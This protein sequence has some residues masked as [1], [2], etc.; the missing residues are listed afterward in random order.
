MAQIT[1]TSGDDDLYGGLFRD[2]IDGLGGD[3][4]ID[5]HGSNDTLNGGTGDDTIFGSD[6]DDTISGGDS[7]DDSN[8]ADYL[9]GGD[10]N[11]IIHGDDG[12]DYLIGGWGSDELYGGAGTDVIEFSWEDDAVDGG[13]GDDTLYGNPMGAVTGGVIPLLEG[14]TGSD[15]LAVHYTYDSVSNTFISEASLSA[16]LLF[17]VATYSYDDN[18]SP[19][20][21]M[22]FLS[23]IENLQGGMLDDTLTGDLNDNV[24]IGGSGDDTLF[25]SDG[26]D[27][28]LSGFDYAD[29]LHSRNPAG[30]LGGPGGDNNIVDGGDGDDHIHAFG[31]YDDIS[32]GDGDDFIWVDDGAHATIDGGDDTDTLYFHGNTIGSTL[33]LWNTIAGIEVIRFH[34]GGGNNLYNSDPQYNIG[35]DITLDASL[36]DSPDDGIL[37]VIAADGDDSLDGSRIADSVTLILEGGEGDDIFENVGSANITGGDVFDGGSGIDT[38]DLDEY[39]ASWGGT[40]LVGDNSTVTGV[41]IINLHG[42]LTTAG[43]N[44]IELSIPLA[45]TSS[46]GNVTVNGYGLAQDTINGSRIAN[47]A[48]SLFLNGNGGNDQLTGGAG[49]DMLNGGTGGDAMAGGSGNDTYIV[50][51]VTDTVTENLLAGTSDGVIASVD[52]TLGANLEELALSGTADIDGTGNS[53]VNEIAGN[54]GRNRL[55]GLGGADHLY[56]EA[57]DDD[58]FGGESNDTLEGGSENDE[59]DGGTGADIMEGGAGDDVY[60][61]DD[62]GDVVTELS[63]Q[64]AADLIMSSVSRILSFFVENLW[65]TGTANI[66]GVGNGLDNLIVGNGGNNAL[67][68][69]AGADSLYGFGGEDFLLGGAG[70]DTLDGGAGSDTA[71]YTGSAAVTIDLG[72]HIYLGGDAT[73][74]TLTGIENVTGSAFAD[75]LVGDAAANI[76][77]GGGSDDTLNGGAGNDTMDGGAGVDTVSYSAAAGAVSIDLNVAAQAATGGLGTDTLSSIENV[78]GGT[79]ADTL[80]GNA[81][82]NKLYGGAGLDTVY[83]GAGNDVIEGGG[84]TDGLFGGADSDTFDYNLGAGTDNVYDFINDVDTIQVDGAY[85]LTAAQV[86]AQTSVYGDHAYVNLGGGNGLILVNWILNGNT[87][88]Q[89]SDDIVI[90]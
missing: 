46:T 66:L 4:T 26:D 71:L 23:G 83:G 22:T 78:L 69:L 5:G 33:G 48:V 25:G 80:T 39:V 18:G 9:D 49:A 34:D 1:G 27:V 3:D 88:A 64:G 12:Y 32:G 45:N 8:H 10:G 63:N 89:L 55:S 70:G 47:S 20:A 14:G 19:A 13:S 24:I 28:L 65:L 51:S 74:D 15:W 6:G 43:I 87:I 60:I 76:L 72:A 85:G 90:A 16:N 75:V 77:S 56:G 41:E 67:T 17:G 57:G 58:L 21:F 53:L 11:D 31:D 37:T 62:A 54:S 68:G 84:D 38:L 30:T 59:L 44:I 2:T 82:A 79:F 52:F 36:G 50:D 42:S 40:V 29:E 35:L 7:A 86:L 73:G 81:G 61:V